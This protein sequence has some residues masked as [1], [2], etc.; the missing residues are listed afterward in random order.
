MV[1]LDINSDIVKNEHNTWS[2]FLPESESELGDGSG[3]E[4]D[5]LSTPSRS[6]EDARDLFTG[7]LCEV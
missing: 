5:P 1:R 7:G 2:L 6:L 4:G 3:S